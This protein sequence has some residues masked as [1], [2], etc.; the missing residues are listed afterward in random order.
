MRA[1][2]V[3]VLPGDVALTAADALAPELR[4]RL[5][6]GPGDWVLGRSLRRERALLL[7]DDGAAFLQQFR[8][9][10]TVV[11]AVL[12]HCAERSTAPLDVLEQV[13]PLVRH[14][15]RLGF[16]VKHGSP[17]VRAVSARL[18]PGTRIAGLRI[19]R[20][21]HL[22]DDIEVYAA[23]TPAG[24]SCAVK[25]AHRSGAA[26]I[27]QEV[28]YLRRLAGTVGPRLID[29]G[30]W[31]GLPFHVTEWCG[32]RN[33]AEVATELRQNA[34][35]VMPAVLELCLGLSRAYASLHESGVVHGD[36]N[37]K[38]ALVRD[39]GSVALIDFAASCPVKQGAARAQRAVVAEYAEPELARALAAK[40]TPPRPSIAGEQYALAALCYFLICGDHYCEFALVRSKWLA[41]VAR[42]PPR[43]F[44]AFGLAGGAAVERVLRRARSKPRRSLR[45]PAACRS[46]GSSVPAR[47]HSSPT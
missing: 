43:P 2:D 10:K 5:D 33:V 14:T 13:V 16:L 17:A 8:S 1:T 30:T 26:A 6:S 38:N 7:A 20:C 32:N 29:H 19:E 18:A 23:S 3:L 46:P 22:L 31:R 45:P 24:A 40:R 12:A 36:V 4:R 28:R 11:A 39:D 15:R 42:R 44:R 41:Q 34:G 47:A 9:P 25:L 37:A 27:A 35:S 21:V